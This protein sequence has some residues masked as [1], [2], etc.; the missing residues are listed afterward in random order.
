MLILDN[1]EDQKVL[2][3]N[4]PTTG[5][6]S[7]LVTCRSEILAASPAVV[8]IEVP[9]FTNEES[10]ELILKIVSKKDPVED[11]IAAARELS[12]KLGGLALAIDIVAKQIKTRKRFRIIREFLPYYDQHR[13]SLYKQP[14]IAI[15][16]PYYTKGIDTVRLAAFD[17]LPPEA[18]LL[19]SLLC[20]MAPDGVSQWVL[21]PEHHILLPQGWDFLLGFDGYAVD[22][23]LDN[24]FAE[25][26]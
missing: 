22:Y 15:F 26:F 12:G 21:Q 11:E 1:V 18:A 14:R 8:S 24:H 7:I 25:D 9:I 13:T 5:S 4:W 10:V 2:S 17:N 16:D 23:S 20:F 6:G 19:M 3:E